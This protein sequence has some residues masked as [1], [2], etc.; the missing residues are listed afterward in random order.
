[1]K[2]KKILVPIDFSGGSKKALRYAVHFAKELHAW[3]ILMHVV[4]PANDVY[5]DELA[6][7]LRAWADEFVP[8]GISVQ[9]EMRAGS[10]V[11]E[12]VKEAKNLAADMMIISTRGR[13]GRAHSLAGSLAENLVQLAPC[14]VLVVR[15]REHDFID[16]ATDTPTATDNVASAI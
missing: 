12:I 11:I 6:H 15:E 8:G 3:I 14:P 9:V 2:T 4:Q 16:T 1:M 7:R 10:E 5:A 13:T